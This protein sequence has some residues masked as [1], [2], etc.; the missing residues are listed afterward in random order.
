LPYLL[1]HR[2]II[3]ATIGAENEVQSAEV[4]KFSHIDV[5]SISSHGTKKSTQF[6]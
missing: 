6:P 1:N 3:P 4:Y 2:A 5:D